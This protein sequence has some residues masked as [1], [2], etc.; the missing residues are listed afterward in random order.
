MT[1][2]PTGILAVITKNNGFCVPMG[3]PDIIP[4]TSSSFKPGGT[5][6]EAL[7]IHRK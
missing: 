1:L 2:S 7:G 3:V 4:V 6:E 5:S